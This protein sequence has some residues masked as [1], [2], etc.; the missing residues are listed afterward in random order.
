MSSVGEGSGGE[1]TVAMSIACNLCAKKC[2][3][4]L[5]YED[6]RDWVFKRVSP[7]DIPYLSVSERVLLADEICQSCQD[8][9]RANRLHLWE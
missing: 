8:V 6:W 2:P 9:T 5:L 3:V 7:A 4:T 1:R